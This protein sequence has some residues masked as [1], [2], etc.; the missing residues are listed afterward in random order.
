MQS[1][2]YGKL[3]RGGKILAGILSMQITLYRQDDLIFLEKLAYMQEP[4]ACEVLLTDMT[5]ISH[6]R[7]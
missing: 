7:S 6:S 5:T 3:S 4:L 1:P 2:A